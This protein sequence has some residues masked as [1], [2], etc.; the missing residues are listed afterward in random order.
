M[1]LT[2]QGVTYAHPNKDILFDQLDLTIQR[3]DKIAL[4]GPNGAGKSTLLQ[5]IAGR[6]QP[7]SGV[8]KT[9]SEPYLAPQ[10]FSQYD[11]MT[12]A[13]ALG[14]DDRLQALHAILAGD[15]SEAN[16]QAL[17]D[18]WAIEERCAA[19][20]EHWGLKDVAL[21]QPMGSLSG[22]QKTKVFLAGIMI[23]E[24]E[25][26]LLDEP[27]NHLDAAGR[28]L[29]YDYITTATQ[30]LVVVSHDRTLLNLLDTMYELGSAGIAVYGGNYDFY[31]EQK[32]A[33]REAL[34]SDVKNAEKALRKAKE[35]EREAME[36]Q[37]KLDARGKRKQ[38]KAGLPTISMNTFRNSAEKST[39]RMKDVHAGK[40]ESLTRDLLDLRN[41]LPD[42]DQMKLNVDDSALHKG[43]VLVKAIGI[44]AAPNGKPLW[45]E[46]LHF[47]IASG[48]R[49]AIA[50]PNGSGKTTLLRMLLGEL[51]PQ[52][53]TIE[54]ADFRA[55]YI[56]QDYS[57]IRNGLTVYEQAQAYNTGGLQEHEIKTRL[58]RF[59]F[60]PDDWDKS[61]G[62]LSGGERMRLL[63]CCL[64]IGE[65]APDVI[66]LD[67]PTNNLDI[68]NME[69]LTAAL[70]GYRG[71]LIV[72]SHDR[73]FLEEI[74]VAE[75]WPLP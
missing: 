31:A 63:L 59:L 11:A 45:P 24:P 62:V 61:C 25:I 15:V 27:S 6:L 37:Q 34:A 17:H 39:A 23:H 38:E 22:G 41:A 14:I 13:Q 70:A 44:Q 51:P 9:A 8:V 21:T 12:V 28:Q 55:V 43:K 5:I 72:V 65:R 74:G 60:G 64:T 20:F 75:T 4:L 56:D 30:T 33:E 48:S 18:D 32:A 67:E 57:V 7:A 52:E 58:N 73:R 54:K 53:G 35:T 49:T 42:V 71:T 3:Y 50:G 68:R 19:A 66:V 10:H 29:L 1:M 46:P 2:L 36:R 47:G 69:I 40:V 16:M 26:V